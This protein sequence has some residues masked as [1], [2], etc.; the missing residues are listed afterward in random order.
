MIHITATIGFNF[1]VTI[2]GY[3]IFF[4]LLQKRLNSDCYPDCSVLY[5]SLP[6]PS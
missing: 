5:S 3:I 2:P 4:S 6:T 1:T